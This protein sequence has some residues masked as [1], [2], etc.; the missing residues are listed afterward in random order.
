MG[1]TKKTRN[2]GFVFSLDAGIAFMIAIGILF[3]AI[4]AAAENI[5]ENVKTERDFELWKNTVFFADAIVKNN[6]PEQSVLGS[7]VFDFEKQRVKSNEIDLKLLEKASAIENKEFE[8]KK[9]SLVFQDSEKVFFEKQT[10][11]K[12]CLAIERIVL[13]EGKIAKLVL[14]GC[15]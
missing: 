4:S 7:A 11:K 5:R 2:K 10:G 6:S 14:E 8:L 3:V 9:I 13:A 15:N 12:N 1:I